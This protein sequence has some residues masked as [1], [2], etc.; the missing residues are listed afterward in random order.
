MTKY[1]IISLLFSFSLMAGVTESKKELPLKD[2]M[3]EGD[4]QLLKRDACRKPIEALETKYDNVEKKT[5]VKMKE[6]CQY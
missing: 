3:D 2:Q 5:L 1:L 4:K 6:N